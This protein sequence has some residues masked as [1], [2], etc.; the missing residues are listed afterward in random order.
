MGLLVSL[1]SMILCAIVYVRMYRRDLPEPIGKKK[2]ALPVILGIF[3]PILSVIAAGALSTLVLALVGK[4]GLENI[5]NLVLRSLLASFIVA[6]FTEEIVK[7]LL[8]LSVV[9]VTKPRTV[10]Q[11]GM[12]CAG[13]GFGFTA[14][15][16]LLYGGNN[17][18]TALGR[19]PTFALH[20]VFGLI[21]GLQFGLA[22]YCRVNGKPGV[23]KHRVLALFLPV[24]WHTLYD[25]STAF[26]AAIRSTDTSAQKIGVVIAL[27][28]IVVSFTLQIVLLVSF[29]RRSEA[30][31]AMRIDEPEGS[32]ETPAEA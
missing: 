10:Y 3:A 24:L 19:I 6:G 8:F 17:A 11:T 31:S 9:K 16:I 29:L 12:L 5:P 23:G 28:A 25:A 13:I 22:R 7:G 4:G 1:I 30:Y 27:I 21:M 15:E 32:A 20:M 2:A 18:L 26:N 14:L